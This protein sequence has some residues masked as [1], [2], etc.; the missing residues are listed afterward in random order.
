MLQRPCVKT[1]ARIKFG[2]TILA[3]TGV[4]R[5]ATVVRQPAQPFRMKVPTVSAT[6][7]FL[8]RPCLWTGF[9]LARTLMNPAWR[10]FLVVEITRVGFCRMSFHHF[11]SM[12]IEL[13]KLR[14][15]VRRA[16]GESLRRGSAMSTA[17]TLLL[18]AFQVTAG[19][20]LMLVSMTYH[21]PLFFSVVIGLR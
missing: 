5:T 3:P 21:V 15:K 1:L 8:R 18:Y 6:R 9:L 2:R 4:R 14:R 17:L 13:C 12:S 19:Y 10:F 7:T 11:L 16:R 20:L